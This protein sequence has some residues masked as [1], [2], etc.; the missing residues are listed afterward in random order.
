MLERLLSLLATG[1]VYTPRELAGRLGVSEGL[2]E[3]MLTDLS[4]IG[5]LRPV[6]C[7]TCHTLPDSHSAYCS[8]CPLASTCAV[9]R[10]GGRVWALTDKALRQGEKGIP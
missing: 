4:Q 1:G 3:Q 7:S 9:A 6:L 2:L 8:D 10:P 5:Y